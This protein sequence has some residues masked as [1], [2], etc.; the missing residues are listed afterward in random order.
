MLGLVTAGLLVATGSSAPADLIELKNGRVIQGEILEGTT[1][2]DALALKLHETGGTLLLDWDHV[3]PERAKALRIKLQ[4]DLEEQ[5]VV[6]ITGHQLLLNTG[7]THLG[8]IEN[9]DETEAPFRVRTTRGTR[10]YPQGSVAKV[11]QVQV[12]IALVFTPREAYQRQADEAPPETARDHFELALYASR[13]TD[14]EKALVHLQ[15]A[16]ADTDFAESDDGKSLAQR[17]KQEQILIDAQ[18]AQDLVRKA[19]L[20]MARKRWNEARDLVLELRRDVTDERILKAVRADGLE[21]S[22]VRGRDKFFLK[23]VQRTVYKATRDLIR[24]KCRE[25]KKPSLDAERGKSAPGTLA[26]AK[27]WS[28]RELTNEMW[29]KVAD[30][31]GLELEEIQGYWEKRAM[32]QPQT[33]S[34]GTGTFIVAKKEL[35]KK[36]DRRRPA[37]ANR[38]RRRS[39][40]GAQKKDDKPLTDEE[41]WERRPVNE[42]T[43]WL[44][45]YYVEGSG[46]FEVIRRDETQKCENCGGLGYTSTSST[47]GGSETHICTT[48]NT[49]GKYIRVI[50]R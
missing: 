21:R 4:I 2:E 36:R 28:A 18:G 7:E 22:V 37:G 25:K 49:A 13:V 17:M 24:D 40:G 16:Q 31:T 10:E 6:T 38:D 47:G 45:S 46:I 1:T 26:A 35:P 12:D 23:R 20:A 3:L 50:F 41:W 42:R 5:E 30:V 32:R 15:A 43:L 9:P 27:Q 33:A 44:L 8:L 19:K 14:H 39:G 34:Y 29:D 48:C 11:S